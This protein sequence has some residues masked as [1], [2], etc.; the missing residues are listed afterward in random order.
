MSELRD[1]LL[2]LLQ[3]TTVFNATRL[4]WRVHT[5]GNR[6]ILRKKIRD[7]TL[8]DHDTFRLVETLMNLGGR[9]RKS[10]FDPLPG[11]V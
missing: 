5:T 4:G 8:M 3:L 9:G 7:M 2:L 11:L 6:I 10:N 1:C